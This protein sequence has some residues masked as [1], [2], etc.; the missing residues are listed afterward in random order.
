MQSTEVTIAGTFDL[1][2]AGHIASLIY[3]KSFGDNL[4]VLL[5]SDELSFKRKKRRPVFNATLRKA[6]LIALSCVDR[7]LV[8]DDVAVAMQQ[9]RPKLHVAGTVPVPRC[10]DRSDLQGGGAIN[11]ELEVQ[12][13]P[14][15]ENPKRRI[16]KNVN[17]L[18][19]VTH[20]AGTVIAPLDFREGD[21]RLSSS[22]IRKIILAEESGAGNE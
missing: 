6:V 10:G 16:K 9:I 8:V 2:H 21:E 5:Y 11:Q 12:E 1:L 7:V 14:V 22:Y 3:A 19:V 13:P 4:T 15:P 18:D 17:E 20:Y